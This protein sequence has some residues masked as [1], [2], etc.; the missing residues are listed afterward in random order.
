MPAAGAAPDQFK[1]V[2]IGVLARDGW[3]MNFTIFHHDAVAPQGEEILGVVRTLRV[4]NKPP[5]H[6]GV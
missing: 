5:Q 2:T 1:Y 3:I 6:G 4:V